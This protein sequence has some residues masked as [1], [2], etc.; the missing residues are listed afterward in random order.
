MNH[1][2]FRMMLKTANLTQ[3]GLADLTG[4]TSRHINNIATGRA[5]V[6]KVLAL[7]LTLLT[8]IENLKC[9]LKRNK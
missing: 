8:T 5:E 6:P 1:L 9:P 4:Y 7:V 3:K 2:Q